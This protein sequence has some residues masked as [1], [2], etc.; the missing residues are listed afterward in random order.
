MRK[1]LSVFLLLPSLVGCATKVESGFSKDAPKTYL[2][3]DVAP[4]PLLLHTEQFLEWTKGYSMHIRDQARGLL[5]TDWVYD[6]PVEKHQ[7]TLRINQ[8]VKGSSMLSAHTNFQVFENGTWLERPSDYVYD[9]E[10]IKEIE[11][12]LE[13]LRAGR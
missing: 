5:V 6:S 11:A 9:A 13:G 2:L 3:T 4:L 8:D 1:L 12:H 7:V 10:L